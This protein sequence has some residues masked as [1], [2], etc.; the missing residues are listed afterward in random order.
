MCPLP[1]LI[2]ETEWGKTKK[3]PTINLQAKERER[4]TKMIS[5]IIVLSIKF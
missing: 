2:K 1:C 5:T 3:V 4:E